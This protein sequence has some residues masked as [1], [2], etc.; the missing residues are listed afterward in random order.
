MI[1]VAVVLKGISLEFRNAIP[2]QELNDTERKPE[3]FEGPTK[4]PEPP[5]YSG[6]GGGGSASSLKAGG[7]G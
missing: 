3:K 1:L 5:K 4:R 2:N 6:G 7:S